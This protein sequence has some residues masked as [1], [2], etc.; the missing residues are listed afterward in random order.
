MVAP[1]AWQF[2]VRGLQII[3]W[4]G[5]ASTG[6]LP[7]LMCISPSQPKTI[8]HLFLTCPVAATVTD[9]L[10]RLWQAMTGYLPVVSVAGLLATIPLKPKKKKK[11]EQQQYLRHDDNSGSRLTA[12]T[13][14]M[15][16]ESQGA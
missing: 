4:Q 9:C 6:Q 2:D 14:V 10:C 1:V 16:M 15:L 3:H 13:P 7:F 12:L 5:H 11:A 8:S